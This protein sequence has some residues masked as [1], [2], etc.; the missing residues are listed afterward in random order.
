MFA[1]SPHAQD[2]I[3]IGSAAL[4]GAAVAFLIGSGVAARRKSSKEQA[5]VAE[6]D[7][8]AAGAVAAGALPEGAVLEEAVPEDTVPEQA[9]PE[10]AGPEEAV[11]EEGGEPSRGTWFSRR[12][13]AASSVLVIALAVLLSTLVWADGSSD[14][15]A[16]RP[17]PTPVAE[18]AKT[19]PTCDQAKIE[20][21][22]LYEQ[23]LTRGSTGDVDGMTRTA[24]TQLYTIFQNSSCFSGREG[25]AV[26]EVL[27]QLRMSPRLPAALT[28]D[29]SPSC[30]EVVKDAVRLLNVAKLRKSLGDESAATV[31]G[32]GFAALSQDDG[33]CLPP[34]AV[35][36][37]NDDL[38]GAPT[39]GEGGKRTT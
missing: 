21:V 13:I 17:S 27:A 20:V 38:A 23:L 25:V 10:D 9:V 33:A 4:I 22:R 37:L 35:K 34:A 3:Q 14:D 29:V 2:V 26:A 8:V 39:G 16:P 1:V 30:R 32:G 12:R 15:P 24:E 31:L 36:V 19:L 5:S 18:P 6:T 11:P 7:T 28:R